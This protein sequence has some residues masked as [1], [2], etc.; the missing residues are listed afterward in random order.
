LGILFIALLACF[1]LLPGPAVK[2]RFAT[3]GPWHACAHMAAFYIAFLL[4][5]AGSRVAKR[6]VVAGFFLLAFGVAIEFFQTRVY[7]T[8]IEYRDIIADTTGILL[9]FL[10]RSIWVSPTQIR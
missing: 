3:S 5:A 9:G 10:S 4:I 7:G 6:S 1:A 2:G 8:R